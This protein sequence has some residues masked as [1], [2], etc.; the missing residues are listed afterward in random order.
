MIKDGTPRLVNIKNADG[1]SK[2]MDAVPEIV[3]RFKGEKD[4][5][6]REAARQAAKDTEETF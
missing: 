2:L 4:S 3:S 6:V 5:G 1:I